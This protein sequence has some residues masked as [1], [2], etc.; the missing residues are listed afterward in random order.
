LNSAFIDFVVSQFAKHYRNTC[1]MSIDFAVLGLSSV[2]RSNCESLTDISGMP[3]DYRDTKRQIVFVVHQK[4]H[5][6]LIRV[7]RHPAPV[8]ELYEPMGKPTSRHGG[9]SFRQVP[10]KGDSPQYSTVLRV[11]LT[12]R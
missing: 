3:I 5:W 2:S 10:Q 9:L 1:F 7:L 11:L 6:N 12:S 8:L 4:I